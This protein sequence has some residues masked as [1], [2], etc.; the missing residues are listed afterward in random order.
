[1]VIVVVDYNE[2]LSYIFSLFIFNAP[3]VWIVDTS[4][5]NMWIPLKIIEQLLDLE[6]SICR[7]FSSLPYI[8]LFNIS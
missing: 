8:T 5:K 1:M 4:T 7:K 6:G 2:I 3:F